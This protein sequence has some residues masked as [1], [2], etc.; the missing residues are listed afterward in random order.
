MRIKTI[1]VLILAA[2]LSVTIPFISKYIITLI[3][4]SINGNSLIENL[5]IR[6]FFYSIQTGLAVLFA[7]FILRYSVSDMGFNFKNFNETIRELRR[8]IIIWF[9]LVIA[10]YFIS[11]KFVSGF[12]TYISSY[13]I[14]DSKM[15]LIDFIIGCLLAGI[16]EEPLFRGL[17]VI[18]L[19]SVITKEINI[20]KFKLPITAILSGIFFMIAHIVYEISPFRVVRIDYLQL[21]ITFCLGTVWATLF[22]RTKSLIGPILAHSYANTI[23]IMS[24]Y[25]VAYFILK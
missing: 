15:L 19:S 25:F 16:G 4:L 24:G 13:Y 2:S 11:L 22:I 1:R 23:Q 10:F 3:N 17:I 9:P 21:F 8:F 7:R 5:L 18:V 12:S 20:G 14:K 6:I